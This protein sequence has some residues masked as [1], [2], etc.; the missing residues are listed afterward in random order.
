MNGS[1]LFGVMVGFV[2][3]CAGP[4]E[5][6]T[7]SPG[8]CRRV[9]S[10]ILGAVGAGLWI[11]VQTA[12]ADPAEL[13]SQGE[14]VF[15]AQCAACHMGGGNIIPYARGK[16]LKQAAL[17]KNK[18]D[19]PEAIVDLM[20]KGKVCNPELVRP[21]YFCVEDYVIACQRLSPRVQCQSILESWM[22]IS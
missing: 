19:T 18:M 15:K 5:S 22:R 7:G 3:S 20:V 8:R 16:N 10:A 21:R 14:T 9:R 11:G 1:H 17:K 13:T 2:M 12:L 4:A 6:H